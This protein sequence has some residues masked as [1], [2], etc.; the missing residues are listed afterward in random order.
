MKIIV[1]ALLAIF[2]VLIPAATARAQQPTPLIT[3]IEGRH[4]I[5]LN[6]RWQTIIDPYETGYYD[7][8]Y[9]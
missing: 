8:R 9:Q 4:T 2:S 3:N 6:G 5:D 7:Y 1:G